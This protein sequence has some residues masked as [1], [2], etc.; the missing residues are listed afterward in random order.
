MV[1]KAVT[2]IAA[3]ACLT[4]HWNHCNAH[5]VLAKG[6]PIAYLHMMKLTPA[7][8]YGATKLPPVSV[9][10]NPRLVDGIKII[11]RAQRY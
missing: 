5:S 8:W 4:T 10:A 11:F 2:F 1:I 3:F 7:C 6:D 9:I